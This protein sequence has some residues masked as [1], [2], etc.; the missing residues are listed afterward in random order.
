[1]DRKAPLATGEDDDDDDEEVPDLVD[2]FGE[3]SKNVAN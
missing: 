1:V 3:A 2:N